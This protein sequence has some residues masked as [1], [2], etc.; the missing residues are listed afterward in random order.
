MLRL[1]IL[2]PIILILV[3][4]LVAYFYIK[5]L[6]SDIT[7]VRSKKVL[8]VDALK[9]IKDI[10][11]TIDKLRSNLKDISSVNMS[12]ID[13]ILPSSVDKVRYL[14]MVNLLAYSEGLSLGNLKI[15]NSE[16]KNNTNISNLPVGVKGVHIPSKIENMNIEFSV[17]TK[18]EDFKKFLKSLEQSLVLLN[19]DSISLDSGNVNTKDSKKDDIYNYK[20]KLT[21][22]LKK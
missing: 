16:A 8:V 20:V 7:H 12:K 11:N 5:P 13:T 14:N 9:E 4:I 2:I 22:Y 21:T 3:S 6:Y 18:Y 19:V 15:S 17:S 1:R 10:G